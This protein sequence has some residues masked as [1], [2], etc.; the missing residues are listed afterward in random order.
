MRSSDE[1]FQEVL[2]RADHLR[3]RQNERR[4]IAG[5]ALSAAACVVLL[6]AATHC[7]PLLSDEKNAVI[8]PRYGSLLLGASCMGYVV[9]GILAFLLGICVT[10]LAIH[11]R[12]MRE[13][14]RDGQ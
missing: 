5:W 13:R 1:Q 8:S 9:I 11:I 4:V 6:I 3:K 2:R 7:L 10:M 14:E 12:K